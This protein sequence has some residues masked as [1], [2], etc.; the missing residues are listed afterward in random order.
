MDAGKLFV[1]GVS[2]TTTD[3]GFKTF[4]SAFGQIEEAIVMREAAGR[5]RGFG[6]VTFKDPSNADKVLSQSLEL[7]G[8]SLDIKLAVSK[9]D[10]LQ[11][12]I[13]VV[14]TAATK[15][16]YVAGISYEAT[17]ESLIAYFSGFGQVEKAMVMKNKETGK[18]RG[19]GFV[20]FADES[21][22]AGIMA[23]H[24]QTKLEMEGRSLDLKGA[25]PKGSPVLY[26]GD[27]MGGPKAPQKKMFIAGL[28][29]ATTEETFSQYFAAFGTVTEA[30]IQ[31]S[32]ETGESRG[33]GFITFD[34]AEAVEQVMKNHSHVVDGSS[35]EC[36]VAVPKTQIP[37]KQ[38]QMFSKPNQNFQMGGAMSAW[39]MGGNQMGNM[40]NMA[41]Q[42]QQ[43]GFGN[44]QQGYSNQQGQQAQQYGSAAG[45][46]A[47]MNNYATQQGYANQQ[48]PAQQQQ[49]GGAQQAQSATGY[50]RGGYGAAQAGQYAN[51]AYAQASN[52]DG[53]TEAPA[54][55]AARGGYSA[56]TS[57]YGGNA[58]ANTY[59]EDASYGYG[60]TR[61]TRAVGFHPYSRN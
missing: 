57:A 48:Q 17:E 59:S 38:K 35:V 34:S 18:S 28:D 15:K 50:D 29:K 26:S 2:W 23:S 39:N 56:P 47:A 22:V 53:Y 7:D 30:F 45:N 9:P 52:Y 33:F 44:Q 36:K 43:Q 25:V 27:R 11:Q 58:Y 60:R 14:E 3:A 49:Y 46:Q 61:E 40:N 21:I 31:K 4:F 41:Q 12:Q 5:S 54:S 55:N 37:V 42:Q 10:M 8:R 1:A 16:L 51:N 13:A 6:F 20:T 19:F 24:N 32:R